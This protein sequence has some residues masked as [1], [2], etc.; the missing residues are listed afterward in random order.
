MTDQRRLVL[1]ALSFIAFISLGLPDGLLGVAWPT[2]RA[3]FDQPLDALGLLLVSTTAGYMVSSFF[4]GVISRRLGIG[5][6]L[7]FSCAATGLSLLGFTIVPFWWMVIAIGTVIGIGAGAIDAGLN[8]YVATHHSERLMQWLHASFGIG[9]TL[10]P[11]IMTFGLN[12]TETWRTGY[13]IVGS[14]QVAL[15]VGFFLTARLWETPATDTSSQ[16]P[17]PTLT[18]DAGHV[19]AT[20]SDATTSNPAEASLPASL[21]TLP[22]WYSMGLFFAY[23]GLELTLGLWAYSLLTE[24]RGVSAA[25]AGLW[26]GVYWGMFTLGRMVAGVFANR[27]GHHRLVLG[28]LCLAL[29]GSLLLGWNPVNGLGLI[30]IGLI[31]FAFAPIF[32]GMVSGTRQRVGAAHVSNTMGM[33]IAAAGIGAAS[34]PALAGVLA[35]RYSLEVIP[36][37]L[38]VF[39]L[40]LSTLYLM[41]RR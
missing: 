15:G 36:W 13:W 21:R 31:G 7:A 17:E 40:I 11:L 18:D 38:T 14:A 19:T 12:A 41:S 23:T 20:Q 2:M 1:I 37:F 29:A 16:T 10:G 24:S 28:S 33:Q 4:S 6:L 39:V 32:P 34:L 30:A 27:L 5:R 26:V 22:V 25:S 3:G 9:I 35:D 8:T